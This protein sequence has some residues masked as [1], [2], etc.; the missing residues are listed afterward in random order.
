MPES[1]PFPTYS[2]LLEP[3]HYKKIGSALWLFLWCVSS[4]TKE[5]ERDGVTWGIVLGNKPLKR[6]ELAEPFGVSERTVQRWLDDLEAHG[7]IKITR[8]PYGYILTVK[9]SKKYNKERVDKNV[10]SEGDRTKTSSPEWT[11][12]S[13]HVDKSVHSNKDITKINNTTITITKENDPVDIIAER[14]IELRTMLEGRTAYP[15][16]KDYEAIARIVARGMP[17]PQTIKL[18]EQCFEEYRERQPDGAIKAFGYCEKYITDQYKALIA[19][20][21]AKEAAKNVKP[22]KPNNSYQPKGRRSKP[23]RT[24]MLPDWFDESNQPKQQTSPINEDDKAKKKAELQE[25]LKKLKSG[26]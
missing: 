15:S 2:G 17:L 20:D 22:F 7:Y 19:R 8:A 4:T 26:S 25:K 13:S 9:N 21:Q 10:Q 12:M 6:A 24:E 5:I 11:E 14:F 3:E 1:Y 23:I 16:T 18:L